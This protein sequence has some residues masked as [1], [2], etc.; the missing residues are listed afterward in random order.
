MSGEPIFEKLETE[1]AVDWCVN[2]IVDAIIDGRIKPGSRLPSEAGLAEQL[3]VGRNSV[4]EA[5]KVLSAYGIVDQR[6]TG[7]T[8]VYNRF[9]PKILNPLIY[10]IVIGDSANEDLISLRE[11]LE[12]GIIH[13]AIKNGTEEDY[14]KVKENLDRQKRLAEDPELTGDVFATIDIEFHE[15]ICDCTHNKLLGQMFSTLNKIMRVSRRMTQTRLI[16]HGL[17]SYTLQAHEQLY[18]ILIDGNDA[19]ADSAVMYS[20]YEWQNSLEGRFEPPKN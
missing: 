3:G 14:R 9:N 12:K 4:R 10:G 13:L 7:G 6:R 1:S 19:D 18:N 5:I 11:I 2:Q 16:R 15:L 20:L 8:F 17:I